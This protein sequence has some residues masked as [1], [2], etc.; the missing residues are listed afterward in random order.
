MSRRSFGGRGVA[1]AVERQA[2]LGRMPIV[3]GGDCTITLGVVAGLQRVHDDVRVAYFDG[4]AD[5]NSPERTRSGILDAAGVT[6]L[7]GIADTPLTRI[8]R[9]V[10]MLAAYQLA[11]L[12]YDPSDPDSVDPDALAARPMLEHITD[13]ALR[14]DPIGATQRAVATLSHADA[15]IAIHFDV[16]A[17]D[18]RDL[19]LANF[20]HYGTGVPLIAAGRVLETLLAARGRV[21]SFSL[22]STRP[23]TLPAGRSTLR[24]HRHRRHRPQP[25]QLNDGPRQSSGRRTRRRIQLASSQTGT[26][27][28]FALGHYG[29]KLNG[30]H[31]QL[32][33]APAG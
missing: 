3:L 8:G 13:A 30:A 31:G 23:T 29:E 15:A 21:P 20:P 7:L 4:D 33:G 11:L 32:N 25:E 10:P 5:L 28:A 19:P 26:N 22:R 12:G 9:T 17:V 27:P 24:R 18:S 6:H 1:D 14:T 16:D 2:R